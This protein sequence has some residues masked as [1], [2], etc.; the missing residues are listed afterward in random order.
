M[1]TLIYDA[2]TQ[3]AEA[4]GTAIRKWKLLD[5]VGEFLVLR[6]PEPTVGVS[7]PE[8][9]E[10][11]SVWRFNTRQTAERFRNR[12]ILA[13]LAKLPQLPA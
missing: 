4:L 1:K 2:E 10:M 7:S 13:D 11:L 12:K 3:A 9:G 8:N 5:G 6:V